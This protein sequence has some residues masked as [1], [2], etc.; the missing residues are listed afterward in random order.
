MDKEIEVFQPSVYLI[1]LHFFIILIF[2]V[3]GYAFSKMSNQN[4][5]ILFSIT[6]FLG[7][8]YLANLKSMSSVK[9]FKSKCEVDFKFRRF[10]FFTTTLRLN[11]NEFY[12]SYKEE[13]GARG[14]KN[15]ALRLYDI[16]K[17]EL[18][19]PSMI[20]WSDNN[21]TRMIFLFKD[22]GICELL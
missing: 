19:T 10:I 11:T 18:V 9:V 4:I 21:V 3:T 16:H 15:M 6:A 20:G 1:L 14:T 2:L 8:L 22:L 13:A 5:L 17:N 12:Y 7:A